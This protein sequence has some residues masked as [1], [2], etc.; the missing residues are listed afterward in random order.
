[1]SQQYSTV[2][3]WFINKTD[4]ISLPLTRPLRCE[5]YD[6]AGGLEKKTR[7]KIRE[8]TV[9][10]VTRAGRAG[11]NTDK[12]QHLKNGLRSVRR[13]NISLAGWN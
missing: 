4:A 10:A 5:G 11:I 2:H 8:S 6:E 3:F 13:I 9:Q 12:A 1:M 7:K